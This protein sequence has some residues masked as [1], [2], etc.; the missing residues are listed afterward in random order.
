MTTSE[1]S[2]RSGAKHSAHGARTKRNSEYIGHGQYAP[3]SALNASFIGPKDGLVDGRYHGGY[4]STQPS[5]DYTELQISSLQ[6]GH[7]MASPSAR[8]GEEPFSHGGSQ[9]TSSDHSRRKGSKSSYSRPYLAEPQYDDDHGHDLMVHEVEREAMLIDMGPA[10]TEWFY[11][12]K[13]RG[14]LI[15]R[16]LF[17]RDANNDKELTVK[18]GEILEILDDTRKWWKARNI[19]LQVAYV[20][21]T[22]VAVME[23]YQTLDEL[24]TGS[25]SDM[26]MMM[27]NEDQGGAN[28]DS[29][30]YA[31][32]EPQGGESFQNQ[33]YGLREERRNSKTAKGAFRYF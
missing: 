22:I 30:R 17:T 24:L 32:R 4:P 26:M 31:H 13:L 15:V 9:H 16:V 29:Q 28:V 14:A 8:H 5:N 19:D 33:Y 3:L 20:P 21:H 10:Q 6:N 1:K 27:M 11:E 12:L 23:H 18:R 2:S 7:Y 25:S